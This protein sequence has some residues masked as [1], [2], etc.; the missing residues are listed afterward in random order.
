MIAAALGLGAS[1]SPENDAPQQGGGL[2]AALTKE[3]RTVER[4]GM[5]DPQAAVQMV[6]RKEAI[7]ALRQRLVNA[8]AMAAAEATEASLRGDDLDPPAGGQRARVS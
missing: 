4:L 1:R 6:E 8:Q 5:L 7:A 2:G 3:E